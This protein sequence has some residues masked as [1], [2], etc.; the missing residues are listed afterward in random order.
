[1]SDLKKGDVVKLECDINM[2]FPKGIHMTVLYT[3]R[4]NIE[5]GTSL[6]A[7]TYNVKKVE[8]FKMD[9]E[10][11]NRKKLH[12]HIKA[13]SHTSVALGEALGNKWHFSNITKPSRMKRGDISDV[14]L[15]R[16]KDSIY[17]CSYEIESSRLDK[18]YTNKESIESI[19]SRKFIDVDTDDIIK[20]MSDG[21]LS[22]NPH[23]VTNKHAPKYSSF[24]KLQKLAFAIC[25][26]IVVLLISILYFVMSK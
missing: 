5:L 9:Y 14:E 8:E 10:N 26:I 7:K 15:S 1:M 6:K 17:S 16:L 4:D 24:I 12:D 2:Q 25:F 21:V 22:K 13:S 18:K 23:L 19:V 11:S 3:N 20:G